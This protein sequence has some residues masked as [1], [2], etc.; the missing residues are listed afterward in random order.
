VFIFKRADKSFNKIKSQIKS[1]S[2]NSDVIHD[3]PL[4]ASTGFRRLRNKSAQQNVRTLL[5]IY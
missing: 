5:L 3:L 4:Q 1:N 2:L